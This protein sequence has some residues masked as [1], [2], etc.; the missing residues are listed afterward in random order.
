[1]LRKAVEDPEFNNKLNN[2]TS[3]DEIWKTLMLAPKDYGYPALYNKITRS[4][5]ERIEFEHGGK[6]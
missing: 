3:L 5:M 6:T 1:M 4:L 2:A